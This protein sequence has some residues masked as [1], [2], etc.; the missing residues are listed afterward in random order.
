MPMQV[1]P[2]KEVFEYDYATLDR[3]V[4]EASQE[5]YTEIPAYGCT[6]DFSWFFEKRLRKIWENVYQ[7]TAIN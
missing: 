6:E 4:G 5:L 3:Q 2:L 1:N 7:D